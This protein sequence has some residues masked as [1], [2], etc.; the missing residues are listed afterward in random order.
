MPAYKK[1]DIGGFRI[2]FDD[3]AV[4]KLIEKLAN[5][6]SGLMR[7][8]VPAAMAKGAEVI[9]AAARAGLQN[10]DSGQTRRRL[11]YRIRNYEGRTIAIIGVHRG[12]RE[13]VFNRF[14][15]VP[16]WWRATTYTH[17]IEGGTEEHREPDV[18]MLRKLRRIGGPAVKQGKK[19]LIPKSLIVQTSFRWHPGAR[20]K[21]FLRPAM[22]ETREAAREAIRIELES[23]MNKLAH[24]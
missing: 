5:I 13:I 10:E 22:A 11:G 1:P 24:G 15:G 17:L 19:N 21:P 18:P 4:G 3:A 2:T 12:P 16:R 9:V 6:S 23:W 7:Q 20:A 14:T 8:A